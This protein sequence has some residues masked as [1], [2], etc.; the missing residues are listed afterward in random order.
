MNTTPLEDEQAKDAATRA[1][2]ATAVAQAKRATAIELRTLIAAELADMAVLLVQ[3]R[4]LVDERNPHGAEATRAAKK[5]MTAQIQTEK[6]DRARTTTN[7]DPVRRQWMSPTTTGSGPMPVPGSVAAYSAEAEAIFTLKAIARDFRDRLDEL[8]VCYLDP[9]RRLDPDLPGEDA[10]PAEVT[11]RVVEDLV[12]ITVNSSLLRSIHRDLVDVNEKL[13]TVVE[14]PEKVTPPDP[15][16]PV[17]HQPTLV[18]DLRSHPQAITCVHDH[19]TR[20]LCDDSYCP[21]TRKPSFRHTW[22]NVPRKRSHV[23]TRWTFMGLLDQQALWARTITT[24]TRRHPVNTNPTPSRHHFLQITFDDDFGPTALAVCRAPKSAECRQAYA[25]HLDGRCD[26]ES[27]D[28]TPDCDHTKVEIDYCNTI[29]WLN[30]EPDLLW[31]GLGGTVTFPI[32][33]SWTGDHYTWT[34]TDGAR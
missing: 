26:Y 17:C 9:N 7:A 8:G 14:G 29:Q 12:A 15:I 30:D 5:A 25:C 27:T 21:C 10:V 23:D 22:V 6:R 4:L 2:K 20:C 28:H 18:L 3:V 31:G 24:P 16:C 1:A 34:A 33:E 13:R 11:I 32:E 19:T